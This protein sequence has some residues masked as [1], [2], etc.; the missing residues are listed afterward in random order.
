MSGGDTGRP[1]LFD[2]L[3]TPGSL[4]KFDG[5]V[6]F[7]GFGTAHGEPCFPPSVKWDAGSSAAPRLTLVPNPD[8]SDASVECD[9]QSS[10][11]YS[12]AMKRL[13]G[14]SPLSPSSSR[15][16]VGKWTGASGPSVT[17]S[18]SGS[19]GTGGPTN[20]QEEAP[21][22]SGGSQSTHESAD[23]YFMVVISEKHAQVIGFPSRNCYN[24]VK[25]TETSAV[26][27]AEIGSQRVPASM[28]QTSPPATVMYVSC[29]LSNGH[30]LAFSL[31]SLR[32]LSDVDVT[33]GGPFRLNLFTFGKLGHAVY[34]TSPS[35]LAKI[36]ISADLSNNLS[37]M[38]GE[39]FLPCNMPEPPKK[40][41]FTNLFTGS[42]LSPAEKDA[43]F[44]EQQ[45]GKSTSGTSALLPSGRMER[46]GGQASG[47]SSE[48]A[49][50]RNAA[51]ERGEKLSQLD[52]EVQEMMDQS[53]NLSKT[54][55]MLAAKY[56]KQ[57]KWWGVWPR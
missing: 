5:E 17:S 53:K 51:L 38:H 56:E 42:G 16:G 28:L 4:F 1:N 30:L 50:A 32:I 48:I 15:Q 9:L 22:V 12:T 27:R 13:G 49:R 8:E 52:T 33:D 2:W 10:G 34:F 54:A 6:L 39:L 23:R 18:H 44:G 29:L 19:L 55:A 57:D 35:E 7:I 31:P 46:L 25:I 21:S 24:R 41:F 14:P 3:S 26:I 43:L 11:S 20:S 37:E 40:N 36:T 47:A 45:S